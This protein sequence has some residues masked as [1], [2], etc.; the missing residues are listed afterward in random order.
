AATTAGLAAWWNQDWLEERLR[1]RAYRLASARPLSSVQQAAL[2]PKDSFQECADCPEMI[3]VPTGSFTMGAP[4]GQ[5]Q[6]WERPQ[7]R[8]TIVKPFAV[9]RYE[10]TFDEWEACVAHGDCIRNISDRGW[11]RGRRPVISVS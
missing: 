5:G 9:A 1:E 8:V 4:A 2:K 3:V 10:L 11:G 6:D 7:H